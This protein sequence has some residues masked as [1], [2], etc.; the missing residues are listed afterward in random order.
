[1]GIPD[2]IGP[3]GERI[4]SIGATRVNS[5]NVSKTI[6]IEEVII[7]QG[8]VG[9]KQSFIANG[10]G[11]KL[12]YPLDVTGNP[13]YAATVKFQIFEYAMPNEGDTTKN[14]SQSPVDNINR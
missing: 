8:I 6:G 11:S 5:T 14:H 7:T 1:M 4:Q 2:M 3:L 13:A 12:E 9:N 10:G